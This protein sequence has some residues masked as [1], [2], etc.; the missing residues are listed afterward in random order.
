LASPSLQITQAKIPLLNPFRVRSDRVCHSIGA[1]GAKGKTGTRAFI[2]IG[3]LLGK[4]HSFIHD[5]ESFF[6]VLFWIC[7]HCDG[8]VEGTVIGQFDK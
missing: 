1:L 2:A 8:P 6:W 3:A 7:I 4:Q 5:L